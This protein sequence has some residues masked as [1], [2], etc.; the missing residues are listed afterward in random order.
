MSRRINHGSQFKAHL[1][2]EQGS[3]CAYCDSFMVDHD[4]VRHPTLDH[5]VALA[6]GG[7]DDRHNLVLAC[8]QCNTAKGRMSPAELRAIA[9]RIEYLVAVLTGT[10]EDVE[11]A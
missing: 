1:M 6:A 7:A 10:G 2:R 8:V 4:S 9:D 11:A 5:V 3:R